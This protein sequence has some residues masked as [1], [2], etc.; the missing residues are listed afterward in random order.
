MCRLHPIHNRDLMLNLFSRIGII[1]KLE[2][3]DQVE[4]DFLKNHLKNTLIY[5][6][7]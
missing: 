2:N 3:F 6:K 7:T 1:E 5:I 4:L